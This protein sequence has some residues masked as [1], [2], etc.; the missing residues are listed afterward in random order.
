M[1]NRIKETR[2]SLDLSQ[3][4]FGERLGITGSGLSNIE[5][6]KRNVTE[7]MILAICREF[8]VNEDWLRTGDG[9]EEAMFEMSDD[10]NISSVATEF[11]LDTLSK[12]ILAAYVRMESDKRTVLNGFVKEIADTVIKENAEK[13]RLAIGDAILNSRAPESVKLDLSCKAAAVFVDAFPY[14]GVGNIPESETHETVTDKQEKAALHAK[15]DEE[16]A[17]EKKQETKVFSAK[18]SD[19]G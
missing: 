19:V 1:N 12:V 9:G 7:Q 2:K 11:H 17:K 16:F 13:A 4:A 5:S 3:E 10:T 18:E 14:I 8:N 15:L 6:G